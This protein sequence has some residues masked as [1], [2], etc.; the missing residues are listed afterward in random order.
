MARAR[1]LSLVA[2]ALAL[3]TA[4]CPLLVEDDFVLVTA[5]AGAGSVA[6]PGGRGGATTAGSPAAGSTTTEPRA[7]SGG[8]E[9]VDCAP[10]AEGELCS[11]D[12]DCASGRCTTAGTCRAC[13]LRLMSVQT[14]CPASCTRCDAGVCTIECDGNGACKDVTLA[15]PPGLACQV[16]CNGD[17]ACE[18]TSVQC[19]A[20]FPCDV[21]CTGKQS[22]R[23]AVTSCG[24]GPCGMTCAG[25]SAC[26]ETSVLCGDDRCEAKCS[27]GAQTPQMDCGESCDCTGCSA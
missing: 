11:A 4:G 22:C 3:S 9:G 25:D 23:Q 20:E 2:A 10:C 12:A 5:S 26:R 16:I 14:V 13:G 7:G 21:A 18:A 15:C 8:K 24:S 19:P 1:A 17:S 6:N 27:A